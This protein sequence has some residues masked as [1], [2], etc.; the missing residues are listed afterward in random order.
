MTTCYCTARPAPHPHDRERA[1]FCGPK[2]VMRP[3]KRVSGNQLTLAIRYSNV[4][5]MS[6]E[7]CGDDLD[8]HDWIDLDVDANIVN[9]DR[10]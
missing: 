5:F 7:V 3:V 1:D 10:N 6:C 9:C 8:V 2:P 4:P